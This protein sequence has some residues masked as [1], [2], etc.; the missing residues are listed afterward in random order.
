[1]AMLADVLAACAGAGALEGVVVVTVDAGAAA[2]ARAAGAEVVDDHAR[3]R[4][5][6]PAV[7]IGLEAARSR[8]ADAA[9]VLTADLPLA[10]AGDIEAILARADAAPSVTLVPSRD[11]TGTNAM[12]LRPPGALAPELGPASLERHSAQ[13][14]RRGLRLQRLAR[15]GLALD[16]DTPE[17]LA[18]LLAH[19]APC[20]TRRLCERLEVV[21]RLGAG[22]AL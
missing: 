10:G 17:D 8:G 15:P 19:D 22:S 11:G 13:A 16:I 7:K 1:M 21:D 9:L 4:G 20:A 14:R 5:M 2:L 3:P 6:N 18:A 12:L